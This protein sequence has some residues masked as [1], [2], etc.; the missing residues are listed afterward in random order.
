MSHGP[1]FILVKKLTTC[2]RCGDEQLAWVK[3]VKGKW[4]LARAYMDGS[5]FVANRLDPHKCNGERSAA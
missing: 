3:S 4:Y 1:G 2:K 5:E